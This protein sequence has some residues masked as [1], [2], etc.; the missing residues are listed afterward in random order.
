[1]WHDERLAS[2][3]VTITNSFIYLFIVWHDERPCSNFELSLLFRS[4]FAYQ[5]RYGGKLFGFM[6]TMVGNF[7][8]N[9]VAP[10]HEM[11]SSF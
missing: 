10:E 1:M 4:S 9:E 7:A 8:I 2:N 5:C 11:G 6:S 3:F